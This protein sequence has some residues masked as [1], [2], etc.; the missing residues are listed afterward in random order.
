MWL[1]IGFN[2]FKGEDI[3]IA[4]FFSRNSLDCKT[5]LKVMFVSRYYHVLNEWNYSARSLIES[6]WASIKV[7]TITE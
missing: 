1:L 4:R 5:I 6:L 3:L 2:L 7:I